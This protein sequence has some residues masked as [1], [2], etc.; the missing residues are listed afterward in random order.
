[1]VAEHGAPTVARSHECDAVAESHSARVLAAG[2][3]TA[4]GG[5]G[6]QQRRQVRQLQQ[7]HDEDQQQ[8]QH[9]QGA[10]PNHRGRDAVTATAV[11]QE[12]IRRDQ[13]AL[14][15]RRPGAKLVVEDQDGRG[16]D[17]RRVG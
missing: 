7:Q 13:N 3:A 17:A 9:P 1:M 12:K 16:R 10:L 5:G 15:R 8:T 6:S 4:G 11:D 2:G 14:G